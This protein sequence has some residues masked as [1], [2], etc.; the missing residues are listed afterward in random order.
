MEAAFYAVIF[1]K[2]F[3]VNLLQLYKK[4]VDHAPASQK[5]YKN[6]KLIIMNQSSRDCLLNR[7]TFE[8]HYDI[9]KDNGTHVAFTSC[10]SKF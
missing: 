4:K 5:D 7:M 2:I 9:S 8:K 3:K 6:C 10:N 1:I